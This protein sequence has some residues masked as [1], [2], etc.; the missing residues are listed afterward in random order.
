MLAATLLAYLSPEVLRSMSHNVSKDLEEG[1]IE[2]G[3]LLED[4]PDTSAGSAVSPGSFCC[5]LLACRVAGCSLLFVN[6][7]TLIL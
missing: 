5:W 2:D 7:S 4:V 6:S 1:E 3:E